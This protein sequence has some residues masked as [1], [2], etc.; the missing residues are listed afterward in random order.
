MKKTFFIAMA[1]CGLLFF[2]C[3]ENKDEK[4]LAQ[5]ETLQSTDFDYNV[6][7]FGDIKVLRYQIPGW[8][9]LTLKEQKLVYYLTQ[10]GLAGRDIMWDQNY[11]H[12]LTIRKALEN[13]YTNYKGDKTTDDWKNFETYLK[14]VWFS[15]GI[16]HHYS[17]DKLKPDFSSE[18]LK[19]LLT[20]TNTILEGEAFDVVFNDKDSKKVNQAKGV[21][22]VLESAVNFYGPDVT[23]KDVE[24]F[25]SKKKSPD[26]KK[27]LSYGL[28]SKLVKENGQLKELVYKSGGLY[29]SA[30][31]KIVE[32]LEKAQGVAENKAQGDA[33][34]LL[35][36]YYK[37]GD[38]QTWDDYNVAWTAAT[39]GNIDYINSFIEVYNDPL[40]YRGSYETVVQINDF[41]MSEKMA[42]LTENA[43]WFEDNS[44][45]MEE[46]KKDSVVG[47][48]YK[49]VNVAGEAGDSSPSTPIGVNLPNANWIR[50][51][52]GS[53]SV[54]LGNIIEAYNKAGSTGRLK[55]FVNDTTELELEEK[56]GQLADKLH[57]ALHEVIGHAS[58]QLNPGVGETKE[59]LKTYAST[60]EEG[61]ADLVGLYYLYNP[62]LQELGL[63]DDWKKMGMAAYDG[64][65]RNGL[66]TQLIRLNLGDDVEEAHMRNRQWVSA[67]VFEKGKADN[68][69]EK[70][71]RDGKTYF[72]IT[73]YDKLHDLFGQLLRETQ[74]IKSEGDYEAVEKLVETYG[75]KVDQ[76][77]HKEILERN[78]QFT[79]APYSGFVNPV[80]VPKMGEN[81]EIESFT[82]EQPKT[83]AEQMMFYSENYSNLPVVN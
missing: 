56:Y 19:Q 57:T 8:D 45:L 39:E 30:I 15:N 41:D 71:T 16:H 46:H 65:I 6:E 2:S 5:V 61:R 23:T 74:R 54:S 32:W 33:L 44:P 24:N 78:K 68:V 11:R 9:K 4:P 53:K 62:K 49:V 20:D 21:D 25:Y 22:N 3:K 10:A 55:E 80:L 13:V 29:G 18:Y 36:Q 51:A 7:S 17:K 73:D 28:N 37:T 47:V 27:P 64:Y 77:L 52:V 12:N 82:I 40:G 67:W 79:S 50:A 26:P 34:G 31:D 75:V 66:M 69:I 35:I 83:F 70:I 63:V 1:M 76:N 81:G 59:T 58:G 38:L 48:T 60:L 14:R 72:N 43:Q 42:V